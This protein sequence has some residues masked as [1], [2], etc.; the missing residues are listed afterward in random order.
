MRDLNFLWFH[1]TAH[2]QC[3]SSLALFSCKPRLRMHEC[4]RSN[5]YGIVRR[6][7]AKVRAVPGVHT[8]ILRHGN[9]YGCLPRV[10]VRHSVVSKFKHSN[11]E[12]LTTVHFR[13]QNKIGVR[14]QRMLPEYRC[15]TP[16]IMFCRL[17]PPKQIFT[18]FVL[19]STKDP[20]DVRALSQ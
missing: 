4:T 16:G 17:T 13:F 5:V 11:F 6:V 20:K 1:V 2:R 18:T 7:R 15:L 19:C 3:L 9:T 12:N 14:I 8:R 10:C